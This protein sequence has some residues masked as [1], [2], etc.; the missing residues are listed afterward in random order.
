M[1]DHTMREDMTKE[2]MKWGCKDQTIQKLGEHLK[3]EWGEATIGYA[4]G[5]I[6][7]HGQGMGL[8]GIWKNK[9]IQKITGTLVKEMK[10]NEELAMER[11]KDLAFIN[12]K[13]AANIDK[14]M[15]HNKKAVQTGIQQC[16][17]EMM[18][19]A[20]GQPSQWIEYELNQ[21]E[22]GKIA[23]I[24]ERLGWVKGKVAKEIQEMML[25]KVEEATK[26]KRRREEDTEEKEQD[27][28][29]K[30]KIL[31]DAINRIKNRKG[32]GK[33]KRGREEE[34]ENQ[35]GTTNNK[36]RR[37]ERETN[38]AYSSNAGADGPGV[39]KEEKERTHP[40]QCR[41]CAQGTK[42][43]GGVVQQCTNPH[44]YTTLHYTTRDTPS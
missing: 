12:M 33:E 7:K 40:L 44:Y 31:S 18:K 8:I 13:T 41:G 37:I 42:P 39:K 14:M 1:P 3:A 38:K 29:K 23:G 25:K 15:M 34:E 28:T 6:T 27:K 21:T 20:Q 19:Y 2:M 24:K 10:W 43:P 16:E 9:T 5:D 32:K 17:E 36:A 30:V 26:K 35:E 11:A 4:D 22:V